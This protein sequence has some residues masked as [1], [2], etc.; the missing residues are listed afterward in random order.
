M[1]KNAM[2]TVDI[3]NLDMEAAA[4]VAQRFVLKEIYLVDAKI[5]RDPLIDVCPRLFPWSINA[6]RKFSRPKK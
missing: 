4:R 2:L 3:E 5:S 1:N 6:L